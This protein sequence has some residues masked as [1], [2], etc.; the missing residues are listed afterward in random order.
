MARYCSNHRIDT[1]NRTVTHHTVDTTANHSVATD[2]IADLS[3][4]STN[5]NTVPN[6]H[7][8][9]S[10]ATFAHFPQTTASLIF[11]AARPIIAPVISCHHTWEAPQ[12]TFVAPPETAYLVSSVLPMPDLVTAKVHFMPDPLASNFEPKV[13]NRLHYFAQ[14]CFQFF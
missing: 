12:T 13:N 10:S 1:A 14:L 8:T 5:H 6:S 11:I 9:R 3:Q 7:N 2:H 4:E